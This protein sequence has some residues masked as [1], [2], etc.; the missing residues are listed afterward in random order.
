MFDGMDTDAPELVAQAIAFLQWEL[1]RWSID[2]FD[3]IYALAPQSNRGSL[4]FDLS[5][6]SLSAGARNVLLLALTL[7]IYHLPST[8]ESA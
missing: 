6:A 7:T 1:A 5:Q 4:E 3:Q 8:Q 2:L